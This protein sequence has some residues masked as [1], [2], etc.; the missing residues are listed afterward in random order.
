MSLRIVQKREEALLYGRISG[1]GG[2]N[3]NIINDLTT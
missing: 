2:G 1:Q 3:Y